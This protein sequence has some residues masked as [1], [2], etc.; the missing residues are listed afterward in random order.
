[1][2][3]SAFINSVI[4]RSSSTMSILSTVHPLQKRLGY[5]VIQLYTIT[6]NFL[7]RWLPFFKKGP[8]AFLSVWMPGAIAN[9][10]P[11]QLQL[12][13][14]RI[15]EGIGQQFFR[16]GKGMQRTLGY[17]RERSES[18]IQHLIVGNNFRDE[19]PFE[20]LRSG[21]RPIKRQDFHRSCQ[22]DK[23]WQG[24]RSTTVNAKSTGGVSLSQSRGFSHDAEITGQGEREASARGD[25]VDRGDNRFFHPPNFGNG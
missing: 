10:L 12:R 22:A 5:A 7:K 24:E 9:T 13:F 18:Y 11:F 8:D 21:D 17:C 25:A 3:M 14:Q 15:V 20:S 16:P 23:S 2:I 19:S 6:R 1:M 4:V